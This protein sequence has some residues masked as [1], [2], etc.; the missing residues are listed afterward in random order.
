MR[1]NHQLRNALLA[2]LASGV[3]CAPVLA[4]SGASAT[5]LEEIIVSARRREENLQNVPVAVTAFS[6]EQIERAN[7]QDFYEIVDRVPGLVMNPDNIT[8][9]N[10]FMR[11]IGTDIES[12]ASNPSVAIFVDDVYISRA[13]GT[14]SELWDLERVEVLR[15]PQSTL[16]GK[17]VI[18]GLIHF[19][20][21]KPTQDFNARAEATAGDYGLLA[22]RGAVSGGLTDTIAAGVSASYRQHDG[23]A[24]NTLTGE[25]MEDLEATAVRGSLRFMPGDDLDVILSADYTRR[26]GSGRYIDMSFSFPNEGST[27]GRN[28]AF[29]NP[30]RRRGPISGPPGGPSGSGRSEVDDA[31]LTLHVNWQSSIGKLTSITAYRDSELLGSENSAGTYFD[32]DNIIPFDT[33]NEDVP[34]DF[35]F[36]VKSEDVKQFSQEFRLASTSDG[37]WSWITGIYYLN[38]QIDRSEQVDFL[39]PDIFWYEGRENVTGDTD[40]DSYG[41]FGEATYAWQNGLSL[42]AGIRYSKDEKAYDYSH[43]GYPVSGDYD[44]PITAPEGFTAKADDSWDAW[45]PNVV[46]SYQRT[47]DQLYYARIARGYKSG[48]FAA[49]GD[50]LN[51]EVAAVPF[52]PEYAMNYEVG[53]KLD[54]L[55]RRLRFNPVLY[56][57][58][59]TDLQTQQLVTINPDAPP[60]NVIV[61]AGAARARGLELEVVAVP[62]DG[63]QL[64]GNYA[65]LDCEFTEDLIVDGENQKGNT[66]R[67][68]PENSFNLGTRFDFALGTLGMANIDINYSWQD[69]L[70][71]DND[72]N[73]RTEVD[74]Q[75]TLDAS[76]G[77]TAN[78]GRWQVTLWGKNLTDELNL[79]G[80]ALVGLPDCRDFACELPTNYTRFDSYFPPRTY[81]VTFRWNFE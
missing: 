50:A 1:A 19:V 65:Y 39:F 59:Y 13:G 48:G 77:L 69:S 46:L 43:T 73:S 61:N 81:G 4:Q 9:P 52:D 22:L 35:Y 42:T 26:R 2:V 11:G 62:L 64:Y 55:D 21:S 33:P 72:N 68:S 23:Y 80:R 32:W 20:T 14:Q 12:S 51:P 25:D 6:G 45:T 74:S 53:A 30:D 71:F 3:P 8:E 10:I 5:G 28:D 63:W 17:N 79:S 36:Q 66:C 7:I 76:T 24:K 18:G 34:D 75:Y 58:E 40:G 49:E 56:W 60:D 47:D 54:L 67:R 31:G 38:E 29:I 78:D 44:P 70:Y 16:F 27:T 37:P 15:G 57:T 41:I